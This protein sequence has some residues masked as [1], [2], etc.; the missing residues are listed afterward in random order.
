VFYLYNG[1]LLNG[2]LSTQVDYNT[3]LT[4]IPNIS[5]EKLPRNVNSQSNYKSYKKTRH[6]VQEL[7]GKKTKMN[8]KISDNRIKHIKPLKLELIIAMDYKEVC[9]L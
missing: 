9:L 4:H 7:T 3:N 1:I 8:K 6:L 5:T 2:I